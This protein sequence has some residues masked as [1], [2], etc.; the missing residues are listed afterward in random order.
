MIDVGTSA[1]IGGAGLTALALAGAAAVGPQALRPASVR[2]LRERCRQ[3][4]AVCLTFDDGPGRELTPRVLELLKSANGLATFYM[5]G[6]RAAAAPD[7]ADLVKSEGHEIG[8]HSM[9][10]LHA[11]RSP[12]WASYRDVEDG[13]AA[14]ARWVAPSGR[15]RPPYGKLNVGS[16]AAVRRRRAP[17]DWWTI[18]SGDTWAALPDVA[19]ASERVAREGGG[20]VLLHDF[21]RQVDGQERAA[22]VLRAI[23]TI[24][25]RAHSED[26]RLLSIGQA[27]NESRG[28]LR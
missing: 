4:R 5:L 7:I 22:F 25:R 8:A 3:L 10:H 23:E 19:S 18:D 6:F 20:V 21:D 11:W 13:Y 26:L 16:W 28:A 15:F 14:L 24:I 12:P 1:M 9:R 27:M 2:R 17:I